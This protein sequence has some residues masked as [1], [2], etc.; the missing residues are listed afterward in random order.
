MKRRNRRWHLLSRLLGVLLLLAGGYA[1][2]WWIYKLGPARHT[3]DPQWI[4]RHS[5]REYWRE[6][7]TGIYRGMWLHDDGDVVGMF[8]N[9]AWAEWIMAHVKPGTGMG[10]LGGDPCHSATAM[11][12]ITNQDA[13]EDANGWLGWWE[14]N[15][16]KSQ[17]TWIADGFAQRGF[18]IDV[19][20]TPNQTATILTLLGN[21]DT[22]KLTAIPEHLNYNAFRC[23]RDVGFDPVA[24]ALSNHAASADVQRGLLEF[25]KRQRFWPASTG[26]GALP[27]AKHNQGSDDLDYKH[28][29]AMLSLRFQIVANTL[30]IM[31]LIL[32]A[33]LVLWSFR[34]KR[35][36][37]DGRSEPNCEAVK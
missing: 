3:L 16:S 15:K 37:I 26:L 14:K 19:P 2:Y 6:V 30:V 7:Q 32:G 27:F 31:P 23:L 33:A 10:C 12:F 35:P 9:K 36:K 29:P 34:K 28:L 11:R 1:A 18:K 20:P 22:N 4:S 25:A 8:G 13:G 21:S 24:F 5:E 17:E